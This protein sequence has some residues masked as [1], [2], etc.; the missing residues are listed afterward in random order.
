MSGFKPFDY[1]AIVI[2]MFGTLNWL[3]ALVKV[4]QLLVVILGV[5]STLICFFSLLSLAHNRYVRR[6][7]PQQ[8]RIYLYHFFSNLVPA[9]YIVSHLTETEWQ[10]FR[11]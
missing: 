6:L 8:Q 7:N 11:C 3:V 9:I 4:P 10:R 5:L 1:F 2:G